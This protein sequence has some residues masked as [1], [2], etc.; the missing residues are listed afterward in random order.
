ML[1]VAARGVTGV[2]ACVTAHTRVPHK[3]EG[4]SETRCLL[5]GLS[6]SRSSLR[7]YSRMAWMALPALAAWMWV[8][9]TYSKS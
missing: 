2:H 6:S 5:T 1:A 4:V 3:A 8:G 7:L 9:C